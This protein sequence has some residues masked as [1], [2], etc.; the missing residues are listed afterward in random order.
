MIR[1]SQKYLGLQFGVICGSRRK[2]LSFVSSVFVSHPAFNVLQ[3]AYLLFFKIP[4]LWI[5]MNTL[6]MTDND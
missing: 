3:I 2:K 1:V 5:S 4:P 6:I